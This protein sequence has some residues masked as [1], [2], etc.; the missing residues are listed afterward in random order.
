M[1]PPGSAA[2][3]KRHIGQTP[4][5]EMAGWNNCNCTAGR[6]ESHGYQGLPKGSV[7]KGYQGNQGGTG[8]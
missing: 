6:G 8:G 4:F 2:R 5:L 3:E 1:T 7:R